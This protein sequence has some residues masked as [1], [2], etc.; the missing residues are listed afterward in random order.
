KG[1]GG[2]FGCWY[3]RPNSPHVWISYFDRHG[4]R[5]R[6]SCGSPLVRVARR[7]LAQRQREM[8]D[9]GRVIGP[10]IE[11][12]R[13]ADLEAAL[14]RYFDAAGKY[15]D[16][17]AR[18]GVLRRVACLRE[19]FG[20]MLAI[21]IRYPVIEAYIA[22]RRHQG[23]APATIKTERALLHLSMVRAVAEDLLVAVPLFPRMEG[24]PPRKG[25]AT[26]EEIARLISCLPAY[27]QPLVTLQYASGWRGKHLRSLTWDENVLSG[28][29]LF[30][31]KVTGNK[32]RAKDVF[33][34]CGEVAWLNELIERQRRR[35]AEMTLALGRGRGGISW[36][37][38]NTDGQQVTANA[39]KLAWERARTKAGLPHLRS[40]DCR[41]SATQNN[42]R[43]GIDKTVRMALV[44]HRTESVHDDYDDAA[45][46]ELRVAVRV[47]GNH[48]A[49][50]FAVTQT[51]ILAN[52]RS[53]R[54][55]QRRLL[56]R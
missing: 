22:K 13:F 56:T 31:P 16:P 39:Y 4:R 30:L 27:L 17:Q 7:L 48:L 41:R 12:T 37:F 55:R 9:H 32:K 54:R 42:R 10:R 28:N 1:S 43:L 11:A 20:R 45:R 19:H 52:N 23:A 6:E 29:V 40:H 15:V 53:P 47:I 51:T 35:V 25:T 34:D 3:R 44:G 5:H 14:V 33:F 49:P 8:D 46:E 26:P 38:P 2:G 21:E 50:A 24:S 36:L 18:K